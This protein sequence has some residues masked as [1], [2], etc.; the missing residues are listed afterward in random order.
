MTF[1]KKILLITFLCMSGFS[2]QAINNT[3]F[4]HDPEHQFWFDINDVPAIELVFDESEWR[5]ML[6]STKEVRTEVSG[7]L[8]YT[9]NGQ[10]HE[11]ENIGIKVSGNS[12]FCIAR[13]AE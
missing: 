12:S 10:I 7:T 5:R 8:I 13:V 4:L 9:K 6:F 1:Y 2:A 11:L 3:D